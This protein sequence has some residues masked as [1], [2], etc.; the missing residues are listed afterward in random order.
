MDNLPQVAGWRIF[1]AITRSWFLIPSSILIEF[2]DEKK[3]G[4]KFL[5]YCYNLI[6]IFHNNALCIA[7]QLQPK[8]ED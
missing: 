7:V 4:E 3:L 2:R 5:I 1:E 8:T 6:I